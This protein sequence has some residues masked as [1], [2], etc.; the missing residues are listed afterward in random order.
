M[1]LRFSIHDDWFCLQWAKIHTTDSMCHIRTKKSSSRKMPWNKIVK[2]FSICIFRN[3]QELEMTSTIY[4]LE[5]P[6][7][8]S[9]IFYMAVLALKMIVVQ[10]T[11]SYLRITRKVWRTI[12]TSVLKVTFR[13]NMSNVSYHLKQRKTKAFVKIRLYCDVLNFFQTWEY[14][15]IKSGKS[16]KSKNF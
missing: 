7:F 13:N 15:V 2:T 6:L 8:K 12:F 9:F 14:S 3:W 16:W 5:N 10:L 1:R 11:T 4:S